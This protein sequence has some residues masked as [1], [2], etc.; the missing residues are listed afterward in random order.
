MAGMLA[1]HT[2]HYRRV[3]KQQ[4]ADLKVKPAHAALQG[5]SRYHVV[6]LKSKH[7]EPHDNLAIRPNHV[8]PDLCSLSHASGYRACPK[9]M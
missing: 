6:N 7:E 1:A 2:T 5:M 3:Q 4:S 8:T 9:S